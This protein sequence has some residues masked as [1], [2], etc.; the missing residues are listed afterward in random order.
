MEINVT[1]LGGQIRLHTTPGMVPEELEKEVELY[2]S[3]LF[4]AMIPV[5]EAMPVWDKVRE[6]QEASPEREGCPSRRISKA[7]KPYLKIVK[8]E[9]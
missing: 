2:F 9:E 3:K 4:D 7:L 6:W 8:L 1:P 5:I